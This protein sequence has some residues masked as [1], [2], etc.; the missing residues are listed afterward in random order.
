MDEQTSL[1]FQQNTG[2][3]EVLGITF[4]ND[5]TRR[6]YFRNEL[7]KKLPELKKLEGFPIG[8]DEDIIALSDPPYFTACPNPWTSE[9]IIM[10]SH[11]TLSHTDEPFAHDVSEGKTDAYY[12]VHSYHTK[13]PQKAIIRY[14]LHYTNPGDAIAD[15]FAGSGMTGVAANA[16]GNED[17][18]AA[19][20]FSVKNGKVFDGE[21]SLGDFGAR[22]AVI[23]DLS[24]LA[25]HIA[26]NLNLIKNSTGFIDWFD[27]IIDE[28]EQ[29]YSWMYD[30]DLDGSSNQINYTIWGQIFSCPFCTHDVDF[31]DEA[32][33]IE[34]NEMKSDFVC[35]SCG[36]ILSKTKLNK[37]FETK[38]DSVIGQQTNMTKFI[39]K[40][41]NIKAKGSNIN[42]IPDR[43][44]LENILKIEDEVAHHEIPTTPITNGDEISRVMNEGINYSHQ[45]L[46]PRIQIILSDIFNQIKDNYFEP[47][48]RFVLTAAMNNLNKLYRWRMSGKGGV[49]SGTYYIPSTY[50]ENN[51]FSQL[52][53]KLSDYEK[54]SGTDSNNI[55]SV[56]SATKTKVPNNAIEYIFTDP[57]FG[58]NLMY[59]E[60]NVI[61]E[62]W[63]KVFTNNEDEAI[64][65]KTQS[66][67]ISEY[68]S[69][70]KSSFKEYYRVLKPNRWMTVEFSN[71]KASIWNSIQNAIQGA[72][73][74][75]ANV[76]AL[77]KKQ[78]SFKAVT[79]T[80]AVKQDLVIS[81]YK[82]SFA[83]IETILKTRNSEESAWL[84]IG[85]HLT[86]L[87]VFQ[88]QQGKAQ[89]ISERTPR[90]L[91]DRMVAFHVQNGLPV[92]ISSADF[93]EKL[94]QKYVLRDGMIFLDSQIAEYD[95]KRLVAKDFAQQ[96]LFVSDENSA[97]EWLRQKLMKK[98]Q[99]RQDIQPDFMKEIQHIA[100]YEELP[101]LDD[102]L[103]QNFLMYDGEDIVPAQIRTYLT[104]MYHGLRGKDDNDSE[105]K[106]K[107]V[108]RWYVPDPNKQADLEKLRERTLLREFAH[109]IEEISTSKK[110]LKTFRTEAIRVGFKK[111][112]GDKDYQTIVSIGDKLPEKVIQEDD[113][114]LM[115]YDNAVIRTEM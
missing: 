23:S 78:G 36:A 67:G 109:Y 95:K 19:L 52:R 5:D 112:W 92:P 60:L 115:Y 85:E 12:M 22:Q 53:R 98:P 87:P 33:D 110:K 17:N 20:G 80:T 82:P 104:Q 102:L 32:V 90:I 77:D 74:V 50:Q 18:L 44:D 62:S 73:F 69:L 65:N 3:V 7:R 103:K 57:P 11:E 76:A 63:L 101:E 47:Q 9:L 21:E 29:K 84:F 93:Q 58:A 49:T 4:E 24:P 38:Y 100:S 34:H 37:V 105:L 51:P 56:S 59:S 54:L 16:L 27:R 70:M 39:P 14:L 99:S 64:V 96:A 41:I 61:W 35:P 75:I 46:T 72:G 107:A 108:N 86:K 43:I 30:T 40:I 91:F 55:V 15:N 31:W 48:A 83:N 8:E 13:V 79:T 2:P 113:K 111:A 28:T 68:E 106:S 89:I 10:N 114:L 42:K 26:S 94:T 6:E 71:S 25:Y 45:L 81:A 66:K 97:I 1:E 88:G